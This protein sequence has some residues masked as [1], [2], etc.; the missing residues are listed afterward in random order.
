MK[1]LKV[2]VAWVFVLVLVFTSCQ[3]GDKPTTNASA[4]KATVISES[5][6]RKIAERIPANYF[7]N[8]NN[9][10]NAANRGAISNC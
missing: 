7:S 1:H 4:Y 9:N 10:P 6:A 2:R 8:Q 3:K 5:L